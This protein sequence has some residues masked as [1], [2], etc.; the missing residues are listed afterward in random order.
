MVPAQHSRPASDLE[1]RSMPPV[2][3][4]N[5]LSPHIF[6]LLVDNIHRQS[7][8]DED[9]FTLKPANGRR[10]PAVTLT[11]FAYADDIAITSDSAI[12]AEITLRR[13]QFYSEAVGLKLNARK[14][15]FFMSDMRVIQNQF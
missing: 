2:V 15:K 5:T 3:F 6:I 4:Y 14:G 10:H 1:K 13:L 7:L 11:A 8:V 9:G 12:G